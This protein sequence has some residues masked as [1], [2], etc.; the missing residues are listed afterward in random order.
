MSDDQELYVVVTGWLCRDD[1]TGGHSVSHA[2]SLSEAEKYASEIAAGVGGRYGEERG[3]RA[4][5][6]KPI[7]AF[8]EARNFAEVDLQ[9]GKW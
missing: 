5:I 4:Y 9:K 2:M 7:K 8:V 3:K 6:M 1:G